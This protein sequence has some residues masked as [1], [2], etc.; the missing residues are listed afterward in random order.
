MQGYLSPPPMYARSGTR[1]PYPITPKAKQYEGQQRQALP[2]PYRTNSPTYPR[3]LPSWPDRPPQYTATASANPVSALL[4]PMPYPTDNHFPSMPAFEPEASTPVFETS[5]QDGDFVQRLMVCRS[6]G[7]DLIERMNCYA[8]GQRDSKS[9][10]V[11]QL[12][13]DRLALQ[14]DI[15]KL[16]ADMKCYKRT[17]KASSAEPEVLE[18]DAIEDR[19][20]DVLRMVSHPPRRDA[21]CFD[22][23]CVVS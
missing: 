22:D 10:F 19:V 16:Q 20:S 9:A 17:D 12:E 6:K 1:P 3:D 5:V 14:R 7:S 4:Q 11:T 8:E 23:I 13:R 18:L 21:S 15:R 2:L